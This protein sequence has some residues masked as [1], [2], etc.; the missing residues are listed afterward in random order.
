M[1][2]LRQP[3]HDLTH[4]VGTYWGFT[5]LKRKLI[6]RSV[7]RINE[8]TSVEAKTGKPNFRGH[9]KILPSDV[10]F[11]ELD[12]INY[13][14]IHLQFMLYPS[15]TDPNAL[16]GFYNGFGWL[17]K[18]EIGKIILIPVKENISYEKSDYEFDELSKKRDELI[19]KYPSLRDLFFKEGD[20]NLVNNLDIQTV[21]DP[22]SL[23]HS[24]CYLAHRASTNREKEIV[25]YKLQDVFDA[26][27]DDRELLKE[28]LENGLLQVFKGRVNVDELRITI[29]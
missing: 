24:A 28:E 20:T 5:L 12:A 7:F 21:V 6:L 14:D 22:M 10:L 18:Y 9:V 4:Y 26:G 25:L 2:A 13:G 11:F 17:R 8:D 16:E 29:F 1:D 19:K 3:G 15:K 27:F 23:F